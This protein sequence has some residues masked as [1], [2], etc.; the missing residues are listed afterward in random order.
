MGRR[1]TFF[2]RKI[3]ILKNKDLTPNLQLLPLLYIRLILK[4]V[5]IIKILLAFILS[6]VEH[7]HVTL[8]QTSYFY[9][10]RGAF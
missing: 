6:L 3:I 5:L 7:Y 8:E 10:T 9:N 1:T 4:Q 2:I